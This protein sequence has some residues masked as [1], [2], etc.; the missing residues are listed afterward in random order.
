MNDAMCRRD[1]VA[2]A[3]ERGAADGQPGVFV[4]V[5]VFCR[6][7]LPQRQKPRVPLR[8]RVCTKI[9]N[10]TCSGNLLYPGQEM[11]GA[12]LSNQPVE[13]YYGTGH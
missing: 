12:E 5:I 10:L 11:E 8:R 1:G 13:M 7:P 4:V 6:K 2:A 3:H 9:F